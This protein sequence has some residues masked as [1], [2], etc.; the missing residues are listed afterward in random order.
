MLQFFFKNRL[1]SHKNFLF[2]IAIGARI[3]EKRP[4]FRILLHKNLFCCTKF[5]IFASFKPN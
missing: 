4:I 2:K 1:N 3:P 5:R